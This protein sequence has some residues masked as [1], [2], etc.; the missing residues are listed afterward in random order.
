MSTARGAREILL[1]V[2]Q[3]RNL[4]LQICS[5]GQSLLVGRI[6]PSFGD[7]LLLMSPSLYARRWTL[8]IS[9]SCL[10]VLGRSNSL[11][12]GSSLPELG[13]LHWFADSTPSW[14]PHRASPRH[15]PRGDEDLASKTQR[16]QCLRDMQGQDRGE[17][18]VTR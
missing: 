12:K 7:S 3:R 10:L 14:R 1:S 5:F 16:G 9:L 15:M 18:A 6:Y 4:N 8:F 17:R 13:L 2:E 11:P